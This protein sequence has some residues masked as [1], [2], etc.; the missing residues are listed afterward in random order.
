MITVLKKVLP[1]FFRLGLIQVSSVIVQLL[2]IPIVIQRAGLD[3]NSKWLT[4]LSITV[5]FS[6]L[7]NFASNQSAPRAISEIDVLENNKK[8]SELLSLFFYV[9][10]FFFLITSFI[11]LL[12]FIFNNT[13][14]YYLLG[15]I[16]LL[17]AELLNP[18]VLCLARNQLHWLS[19]LN[20]AGRILGLILV[21]F[22]WDHNA[23]W[24]NAW[25]G[26]GL[27]LFF[28]IFWVLEIIHGNFRLAR[29]SKTQFINHIKENTSLVISNALVHF[30]QSFILYL[31]SIIASP[32]VWGIYAIIDK[33]IWGFRTLLI[34]FSGAVY[35]ASLD[36]WKQGWESWKKFK[37]NGNQILFFG[38]I[39]GGG[40]IFVFASSIAALFDLPTY[41]SE[42]I[43][44]IKLSAFIPLLTGM[45]LLNVLELLLK[46]KHKAI[47]QSNLR[48]M[49]IVLG[50]GGI[51]FLVANGWTEI[52][53]WGPILVLALVELFTLVIY[54]KSCRNNS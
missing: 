9:R 6:I 8:Q 13:M 20:L 1:N 46:K 33:I 31:I 42:L 3:A 51:L 14:A 5:L 10:V 19:G 24:V 48:I 26:F 11:S 43:I 15:A 40:I 18:Y 41:Q 52:P 23:I 28:L 44:A 2:L 49:I 4:S 45:N 34:S 32:L 21:Y 27:L 30:Q 17:L 50:M 39:V 12:F 37:L 47:Y 25:V 16:P 53:F 22:C 35:A 29:F 7:I 38:L 54:E 36:I